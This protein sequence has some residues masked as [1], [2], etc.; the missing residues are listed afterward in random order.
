MPDAARRGETRLLSCLPR[1][2]A[3]AICLVA[4][5]ATGVFAQATGVTTDVLARGDLDYSDQTGG[6]ATVY[7]GVIEMARGTSYAGWHTHP[8]PVWVVVTSGQ[9]AVYGPDGCRTEY[10]SGAAYLAQA[11]TLYDLRNE[12]DQPVRLEFAGVIPAGEAPTIPMPGQSPTCP[13]K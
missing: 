12:T 8:G 2:L 7:I 5:T 4:L 11:D 10:A 13:A 9:L 3:L 1:S 6:P